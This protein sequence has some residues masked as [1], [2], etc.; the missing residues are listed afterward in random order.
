MGLSLAINALVSVDEILY[1]IE[2]IRNKSGGR[3]VL[4][5]IRHEAAEMSGRKTRGGYGS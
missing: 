1:S 5:L 3:A 2:A 4:E